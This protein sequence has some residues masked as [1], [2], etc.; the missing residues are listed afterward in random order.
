MAEQDGMLR[1]KGTL[2]AGVR[3]SVLISEGHNLTANPT[4][5][6][7]ESGAQVTDHVIINPDDV[8]VT[9]AMTNTS[10]GSDAARDVLE[11]FRKMMVGRELLELTTEH[12]I[13][14]NMVIIG[15]APLHQAPYKGALNVTLRLQQVSFVRLESV[16]RHNTKGA[17]KKTGAPKVNAGQQEAP[18]VKKSELAHMS[19]S[20]FGGKK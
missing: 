15:I 5:L 13:Y 14:E 16:G 9:F 11:T 2:V 3:V 18:P 8:S 19:D 20:F 1:G 17:A 4:K 12:H 7:L 10:G 6:A